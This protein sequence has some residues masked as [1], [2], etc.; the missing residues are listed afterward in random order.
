MKPMTYKGYAARI[1]YSDED[2][3]LIGR[4]AGINDVVGF[5]GESVAELRRAFEEAVDDYV[6]TCEKLGRSPQRAASGQFV[7]RMEPE[8]HQ[9]IAATAEASGKSM[10]AWLVDL[11]RAS[12][13][14]AKPVREAVRKGAGNLRA[15]RLSK[16]STS[17]KG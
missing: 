8:L 3:C 5:H 10:N 4:I 11:A 13:L 17:R 2:E 6:A 14:Q 7:V 12:M 9:A 1:E 15:T 16:H